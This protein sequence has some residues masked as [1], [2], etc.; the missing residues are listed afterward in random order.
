[1]H[2]RMLGEERPDRARLVRGEIVR[3]H[4]NFWPRGGLS[5]TSVRKATNSAEVWRGA[6]R[7]CLLNEDLTLSVH[8]GGAIRPTSGDSGG[9]L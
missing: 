7:S 8:K 3:D 2:V 6:R 5:T 4:V 1:M 9:G